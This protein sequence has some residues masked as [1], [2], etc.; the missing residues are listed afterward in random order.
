MN[1]NYESSAVI[2]VGRAQDVI[3]GGKIAVTPYD[4]EQDKRF[5]PLQDDD[6]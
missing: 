2:E 6:E 4:S 5:Q 1:N 3:L